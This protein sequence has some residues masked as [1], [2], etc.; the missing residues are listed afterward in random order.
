M[1]FKGKID[2][3]GRVEVWDVHAKRMVRVHAVD[4]R[5]MLEVGSAQMEPPDPVAQEQKESRSDA[6]KKRDELLAELGKLD[7]PALQQ[8]AADAGV[9]GASKLSRD[10][11]IAALA[12]AK[13]V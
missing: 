5:E 8:A 10:E 9:K 6:E 13:G 11:L 3:F 7:A 2:A 12:K 1:D 4:A